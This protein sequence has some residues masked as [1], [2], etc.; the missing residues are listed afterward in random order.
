[1]QMESPSELLVAVDFQLKHS[2][3]GK[4][5]SEGVNEGW[6]SLRCSE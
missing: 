6:D 1:M 5:R 2:F 4:I 3:Y